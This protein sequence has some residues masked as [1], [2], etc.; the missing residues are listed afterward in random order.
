MQRTHCPIVETHPQKEG[1]AP[2]IRDTRAPVSAI[3]NNHAGG[4]SDEEIA[5]N[6]GLSV[7]AVRTILEFASK[8][9]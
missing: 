7:E 1:G 4:S 6:F 3:L 8:V 5:D 9:G 2:R